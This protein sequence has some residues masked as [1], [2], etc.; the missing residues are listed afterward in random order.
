MRRSTARVAGGSS[1]RSREVMPRLSSPLRGPEKEACDRE[2]AEALE[3]AIGALPEVYRSVF[4]LRDV[5]GLSTAETA[6]CLEITEPTAKTRLHR[7]RTLLRNR[8]FASARAALPGTFQFAG[9][10]CDALVAAVLARISAGGLA[11]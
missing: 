6:A 2:L 4:M 10:R 3:A 11:V 1:W 7:A 9:A 8:L 5:E